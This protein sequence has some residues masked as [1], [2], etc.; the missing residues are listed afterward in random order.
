MNRDFNSKPILVELAKR[1]VH[2]LF[3]I[4]AIA[5]KYISAEESICKNKVLRDRSVLVF[6]SF[7]HIYAVAQSDPKLVKNEP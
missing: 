1:P 5:C 3:A 7:R 2:G 6:Y 4:N